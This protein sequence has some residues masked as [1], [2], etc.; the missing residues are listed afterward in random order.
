M[1]AAGAKPFPAREGA[2][3]DGPHMSGKHESPTDIFKRAISHAA[4]SLA[5][6]PD[7]EVTF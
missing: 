2:L 1:E 3:Y 5:E 4:R 6:Q 7:L